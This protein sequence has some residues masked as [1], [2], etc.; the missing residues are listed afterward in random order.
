MPLLVLGTVTVPVAPF[1][2]G[3]TVGDAPSAKP[4][5]PID[6][7]GSVP[8][9]EVTPSG[10]MAVPTWANAGLQHNNGHAAATINNGLMDDT[11]SRAEGLRSERSQ[12]VSNA[13]EAIT[14]FFIFIAA[15]TGKTVSAS[16][17]RTSFR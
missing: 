3:L 5:G 15:H 16:A 1:G 10:G 8:S 17:T 12:A 13:A 9:E 7:T 14:F 6:G 4:L 2:T 11:P